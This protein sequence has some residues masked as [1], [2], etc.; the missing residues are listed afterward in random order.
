V[1]SADLASP[2]HQS[3]TVGQVKFP[4][5]KAATVAIA[6]VDKTRPHI[7]EIVGSGVCIDPA[8]IILTC[9]HVISA[10]MTVSIPEHFKGKGKSSEPER[11]LIPPM[12]IPHAIFFKVDARGRLI[13]FT[14]R[15]DQVFAS[16]KQDIGL[17]RVLP[18]KAL[19]EG[20]P[21]VEVED[22]C[23]VHEG[24]E[25]GTCGFPLGNFLKEQIGAATS[26]FTFGR[27]STISPYEGIE[28]ASVQIFQ[29]DITATHGNSGGPVFNQSSQKVI[30]VLQGGILHSPGELQPGLVRCEPVYGFVNDSVIEFV[31][32]RP[33][34]DL[35]DLADM[36]KL[37]PH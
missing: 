23:E 34:G 9:E 12:I 37:S 13:G 1:C 4:S 10:F 19:P 8:G 30:G 5:I 6:K 11:G 32:N 17:I 27:I 29:L 22:Y 33:P 24:L 26:S 20:Y 16:T 28:K 25:V 18:H 2:V 14:C 21:A 3:Y 35:G 7:F 15:V 36:K 31:K